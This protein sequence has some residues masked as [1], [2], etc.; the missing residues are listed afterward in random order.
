MSP[1]PANTNQAI[2]WP[3]QHRGDAV[4]AGEVAIALVGRRDGRGV[5]NGGFGERWIFM[6]DWRLARPVVVRE[7]LPAN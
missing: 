4:P 7:A 2:P 3:A 1:L 5:N 6:I